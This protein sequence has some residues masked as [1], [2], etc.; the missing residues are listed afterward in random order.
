MRRATDRFRDA[1]VKVLSEQIKHHVAEE[2]KPDGGILAQ[3]EAQGVDTGEL[4][5]ALKKKKADLQGRAA[6]L[7]THS[8]R[9]TQLRLFR[10]GG[11]YGK[12]RQQ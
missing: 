2:E 11:T 8:R 7:Q 3:A 10:H 5:Q 1:K 4:T 6:D 9:F 12:E